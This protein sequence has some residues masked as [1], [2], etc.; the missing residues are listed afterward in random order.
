[1][2]ITNKANTRYP[3]ILAP[4]GF[5]LY[6]RHRLVKLVLNSA[7]TVKIKRLEDMSAAYRKTED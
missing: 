6:G 7:S 2:L 4:D 5:L 3:L 1:M